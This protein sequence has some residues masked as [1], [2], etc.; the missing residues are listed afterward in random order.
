M[1]YRWSDLSN[2]SPIQICSPSLIQDTTEHCLSIKQLDFLNR[3]PSYVSPGQLHLLTESSISMND[4][5]TK[6]YRPLRQ[7]LTRLFTRYPADLSRRI[8]FEQQIVKLF[9]E[10]FGQNL[11]IEIQQRSIMERQLLQS[12][13]YELKKQN[14]ILRRTADDKNTYYLGVFDEFQNKTKEYV[15]K[16]SCYLC[17][18]KITEIFTEDAHFIEILQLIDTQLNR[19]Y[20]RRFIK[21]DQLL[22][23]LTEDKKANL[24]LPRLYFLPDTNND[25]EMSVQPRF[26]SYQ[27]S[28]IHRLA[29][30]LEQILRPLFDNTSPSTIAYN[31]HDFI[32]K[33]KHFRLQKGHQQNQ[34]HFGTLKILDLHM[35]AS[36]QHILEALNSFITNPLFIG[37]HP[38]ISNDAIVQ[39]T[40]IVLRN[41]YFRYQNGI[42][43][44]TQGYPLNLQLF[45]LLNNI[46]LYQWQTPIIRHIRIK[47]QFYVRFHNQ[48]FMSWDTSIGELQNIFD[49]V[50]QTLSDNLEMISC[51]GKYARFLNCYIENINGHIYST[52]DHSTIVEPF[53]LP[54]F[55][56]HP[57]LLYRQWYR[58]M[59][60]R[61]SQY[62]TN[63]DD[64]DDERRYIEATFLAN[65]YSVEFV[66]YLWARFRT[67]FHF[68]PLQQSRSINQSTYYA[69]QNEIDRSLKYQKENYHQQ[70]Q[71]EYDLM[72]NK[73][74]ISLTY[75]YD[76]GSRCDFNQKFY[77]LFATII[78][79]DPL[80][81]KHGLKIILNTQHCYL[82]NRL[83]AR[84]QI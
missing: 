69:F 23:F 76:W 68:S 56:G 6:Q 77:Q 67:R 11:P 24:K 47:D 71:Q 20:E 13:Q 16:S 42:Y 2:K 37:R 36:H 78:N 65:G 59:L 40:S 14:L 28:P 25:I 80:F 75:F 27:H 33:F 45:E 18:D 63:F 5:L 49:E 21:K 35:H 17:K 30:Y 12:I 38:H 48:I 8:N 29:Q 19:L 52:I 9:N 54:Y 7:G 46:Y 60:M 4:L 81:K 15:E 50:Q 26:S 34:M 43:R 73:K 64:F 83:L 55:A 39:L 51:I 84:T 74:L 22:L 44:F 66:D 41:N 32:T 31:S 10:C 79:E 3:G 62:C 61:A 58:F 72:K 57:R 1:V 53:V 82:S 70:L